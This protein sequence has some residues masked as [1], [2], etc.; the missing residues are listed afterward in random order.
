MQE[1][2]EIGSRVQKMPWRR[3]Q[4]PLQCSCLE[5]PRDGGAQWAA[6]HGVTGSWTQLSDKQHVL[7]SSPLNWAP[8][9]A[10]HLWTQGRG[11]RC[12]LP[13]VPPGGPISSQRPASVRAVCAWY[14]LVQGER[15][16]KGEVNILTDG[17][18]STWNRETDSKSPPKQ[19][20]GLRTPLSLWCHEGCSRITCRAL[21]LLTQTWPA[22][23]YTAT[24]MLQMKQFSLPVSNS[25]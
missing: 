3:A 6:V 9:V 4:R 19:R 7:C 15:E 22:I 13:P 24:Y 10:L 8:L 11:G 23:F 14:H 12:F 25:F 2:W 17:S 20:A 21:A 5:I 1:T 18:S 16:G